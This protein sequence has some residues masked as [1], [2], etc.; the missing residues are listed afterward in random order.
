MLW[1]YIGS[2]KDESCPIGY[3]P[4]LNWN[5]RIHNRASFFSIVLN[6]M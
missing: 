3:V 1:E 6:Y 2:L 5:W 4:R